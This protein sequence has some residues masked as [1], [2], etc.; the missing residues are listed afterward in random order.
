MTLRSNCA[1]TSDNTDLIIIIRGKVYSSTTKGCYKFRA[2]LANKRNGIVYE[3]KNYKIPFHVPKK[4]NWKQ[5]TKKDIPF[6]L[7]F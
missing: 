1:Y 5:V 4:Y 2:V 3:K 6:L 7:E